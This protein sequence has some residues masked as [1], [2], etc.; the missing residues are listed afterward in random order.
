M[1]ILMQIIHCCAALHDSAMDEKNKLDEWL[2]QHA[3][4]AQ[5]KKSIILSKPGNLLSI[6]CTAD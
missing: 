1:K 3:G 2:T 6:H 4:S 5:Q